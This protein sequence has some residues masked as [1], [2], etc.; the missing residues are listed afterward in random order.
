[1]IH[2]DLNFPIEQ[3]SSPTQHESLTRPGPERC[4]GK[5]KQTNKPVDVP[6][7]LLPVILGIPRLK[8]KEILESTFEDQRR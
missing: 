8:V 3:L 1:M 4:R 7:T 2:S 5:K 6:A